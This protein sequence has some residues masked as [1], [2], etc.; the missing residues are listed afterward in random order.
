[1]SLEAGRKLAH[2][3]ILE[4]I[5]KGGMGE[6][7][8]A[9][10]GKLGRDVAIKV[11]PD[12]FAK[13]EERLRRFQ[14]EAKVLAS[15]NHPNIAS[16]YGLEQSGDTHYLVLELVPGETLAE[17]ISRGPIPLEEAL[18]IA[19]KMAEALEEAHEQNI[20]HRDLKPANVKQTEDGKIKVLDF[21]LAKVFQEETTHADSSMSPTLTRDATRVGVI[22]GTAA[23]MSPEQAKGKHVDKRADVWAFGA[24]VYEM[25]TGK[26]AFVG[27]DVSDT[28]AAVLRAEPEWDALPA[29][30][31]PTLRTYLARCLEKD[32]KRRVRDIGDVRLAI[33]GAFETEASYSASGTADAKLALWQRPLP[34]LL[35]AVLLVLV[36]GLVVWNVTRPPTSSLQV[37]RTSIDLPQTHTRTNTGRRGVAVSPTGTHV[38]Y[39]AN[40]QLY[41]RAIDEMDA[42]ALGGTEGSAPTIPFFSPDGQWIG[43]YSTRDNQLKKIALT[44]GAAVTLCDTGNPYGASW[45]ADDTIV[46][47]QGAGGIFQV[48][49]AGGTPELLIPVDAENRERAH[50]P[51][52]LPDG[53]D[54]LYTLD[55][56]AWSEAQIVVQTLDTRERRLLIEGGTD[57]RYLPTGHLV[58]AL[59]GNLLAVPFDLDRLEV[60]GGPVP[61]VENVRHAGVTGGANFDISRAGMLVYLPGGGNATR[62]L[63]WVDREGHEEPIAAEPRDYTRA[64]ISP[65]G[66]KAVLDLRDQED[67]LWVWDFARETL[68]RLTFDTGGDRFAE[69]MPDGQNVV[70]S[71]GRSGAI[72]L[73]RKAVDGTGVVERLSESANRHYP[74]TFTPDGSRLVFLEMSQDFR[75]PRLAVLTLDGEPAVEPLLDTGFFLDDAHLSPNGRWLAYESD[76]SGVDEIYVRPFPNVDEGRWQI[77]SGGGG[78]ALWGPDGHELF[79][80]TPAGEL[81]RVEIDTEPAFRAGNPE[82]L[83][84]VGSYYFDRV[85]RSFDI[86]PDGQRFLMVKQGAASGAEDPFAGLTRLIVVQNWFEEL[87]TRVPTDN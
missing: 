14:R 3:E 4:P 64:R 43:F 17:Q 38:V 12:E 6:V 60:I 2:Y 30:L 65:D 84:E 23:Y 81:M 62:T 67:D 86:S 18:D 42:K 56:D 21:G 19:T 74:H 41:L 5:G 59:A 50:G 44:G 77:S 87:K 69:W 37:S 49:A 33:D 22:L 80:K 54:V 11:L 47:G 29:D 32:P 39:V 46:F 82:S 35:G 66:T 53:R 85:D 55:H 34:A 48:S 73:Y 78:D 57:A 70:F 8:R 58:Y 61:L 79:F 75:S 1:M 25:L 72:N 28:L 9:R 52:I 68:T 31:S 24:V 27:E 40:R 45:G 7:Y 10:D 76:A 36:A 26:R 51:Q 13:D 71:S 15:L 16:I 83:I 20:V 63:V